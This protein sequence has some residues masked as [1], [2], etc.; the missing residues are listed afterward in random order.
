MG[1]HAATMGLCKITVVTQDLKS[2]FWESMC[3]EPSIDI[4]PTK[5][6]VLTMGCS[7]VS[8]M[9]YAKKSPVIN[10]AADAFSSIGRDHCLSKFGMSALSN[11]FRRFWVF[12]APCLSMGT[13][14]FSILVVMLNVIS[15][16]A[17]AFAPRLFVRRQFFT[18]DGM[19]V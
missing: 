19:L 5:P 13:I 7:I 6:T 15:V 17:Q 16:I 4:G 11:G 14:P 2:I 3:L 9:V 18:H 12:F 10:T 1:T 8:F